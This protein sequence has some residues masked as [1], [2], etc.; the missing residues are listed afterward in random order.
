[1]RAFERIAYIKIILN[2]NLKANVMAKLDESNQG[3]WQWELQEEI[4]QET[5]KYHSSVSHVFYITLMHIA[6]CSPLCLSD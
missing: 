4:E 5:M 3:T 2:S 1:M 6:K